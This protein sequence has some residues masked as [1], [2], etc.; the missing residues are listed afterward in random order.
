MSQ[1]FG[2]N[3]ENWKKKLKISWH[4]FSVWIMIILHLSF[5]WPMVI[6]LIIVGFSSIHQPFH[7]SGSHKLFQVFQS[8]KILTRETS[9]PCHTPTKITHRNL[10]IEMVGFLTVPSSLVVMVPSPSLSKRENASLNSAICSSVS[11]SAWV[12]RRWDGSG[13]KKMEREEGGWGRLHT[14][15]AVRIWN[16]FCAMN[17]QRLLCCQW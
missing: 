10:D 17:D 7:Q 4:C 12:G 1:Q 3:K 16:I 9:T 13:G 2:K 5:V 8:N 15:L 6:T 11:W 14:Y